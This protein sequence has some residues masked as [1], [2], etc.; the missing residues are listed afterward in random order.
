M[1]N[2][3]IDDSET[4]VGSSS[5]ARFKATNR[6]TFKILFATFAALCLVAFAGWLIYHHGLQVAAEKRRI[7]IAQRIK[8]ATV[9]L[10]R[11]KS[12]MASTQAQSVVRF[13]R[14]ESKIQVDRVRGE[15]AGNLRPFFMQSGFLEGR[16]WR[17]LFRTGA[18]VYRESGKRPESSDAT[19]I[20]G[21]ITFRECPA[22]MRTAALRQAT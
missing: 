19:Q 10:Q 13:D 11:F 5:P 9:N 17:P 14:C 7:L 3:D 8:E 22:L 6:R 4:A 2:G 20:G 12:V 18:S 21:S 16:C 1:D 15:N